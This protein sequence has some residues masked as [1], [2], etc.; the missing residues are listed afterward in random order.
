MTTGS[1]R[2]RENTSI[3]EHH[4]KPHLGRLP[5]GTLTTGMMEMVLGREHRAR[6]R[7]AEATQDADILID[8][9]VDEP[10]VDDSVESYTAWLRDIEQRLDALVS[11]EDPGDDWDDVHRDLVAD[12][13]VE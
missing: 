2:N 8:T 6:A 5:V 3:I 9:S 13:A 10:A 11:G 1:L 7:R 4:L 12:Y